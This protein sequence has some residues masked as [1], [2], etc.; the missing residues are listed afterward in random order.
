M[1][2]PARTFVQETETGDWVDR[3]IA[4]LL[5]LVDAEAGP[6]LR[7]GVVARCSRALRRFVV[8]RALPIGLPAV[9]RPLRPFVRRGRF[10]VTLYG[11]AIATAAAVGWFVGR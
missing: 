4:S 3:E 6:R 2:A 5:Q 7:R 11:F 1:R 9:L 8:A 10:D